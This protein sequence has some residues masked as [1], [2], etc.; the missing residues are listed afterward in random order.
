MSA[1]MSCSIIFSPDDAIVKS[2][3]LQFMW[4]D[5]PYGSLYS[6]EYVI[7]L[8]KQSSNLT[9]DRTVWIARFTNRWYGNSEEPIRMD[10]FSPNPP[11]PGSTGHIISCS[12]DYTLLPEGEYRWKIKTI[13]EF[14]N[15]GNLDVYGSESTWS[16]FTIIDPD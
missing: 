10:Y 3:E 4:F 16:Y 9:W 2:D 11:Y 14:D 7:R 1:S 6:N 15:G 5:N 8:Q 12:G 13:I